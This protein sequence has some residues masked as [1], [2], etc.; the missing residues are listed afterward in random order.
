MKLYP[1]RIVYVYPGNLGHSR[2]KIFLAISKAKLTANSLIRKINGEP[3]VYAF[4][5]AAGFFWVSPDTK[6][7]LDKMFV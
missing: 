6:K 7:M 4:T 2:N 1:F 5:V 3:V